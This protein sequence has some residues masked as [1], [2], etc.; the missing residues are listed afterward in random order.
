M[1]ILKV[2]HGYPKRYNAGSEVYS[3]MLCHGLSKSHEVQVFTREENIFEPD[4]HLREEKD[5]LN[6]KIHLNIINVPGERHKNRYNH[7]GINNAY[8]L[9]VLNFKPQIVHIGHLNHL[10]T[11]IIN[12]NLKYK[13]PTIYTLHDFWL[14][15]PRGQFLMRNSNPPFKLCSGQENQKCARQCYVGEGGGIDLDK[16]I[17]RAAD[18][19]KERMD[20]IRSIVMNVDHFISPSMVVAEKVA[21]TL[22][23]PDHK[24]TIM[25]YGFDHQR[26]LNRK[27]HPE[28][29]RAF[30]FG[31]IGTHIPSKGI[32]DLIKAFSLLD[33]NYKLR[34]WG[35]YHPLYT[36]YLK[37][38][39]KSLPETL[40]ERISFMGEYANEDIVPEIFNHVD[41]I[42]VPSIWYEN[43]PLVIHEA[44]QVKVP[45][46]ATRLGGMEEY[47]LHDV[48]GL[49]FEHRN[50]QSLS[51]EMSRLAKDSN[52]YSRIAN[53]GYLFS[54][55]SQIPKME[56][57]IR[58]IE[59]IYKKAIREKV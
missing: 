28:K 53:S 7:L 6:S 38:L 57:H 34:I 55:N 30:V 22:H 49:L 32:Q 39:V 14:A 10:S 2:I 9:I 24:I 20:H 40:Q 41:A 23:I 29:D 48:N 15:C 46:I 3:Q 19:V 18:W 44:Q 31:Y 5:E 13:I 54:A 52:L 51:D 8:S 11:G 37:E 36:P 26:L 50:V 42:V 45:V 56:D 58:E 35:R 47:I 12:E 16:D 27:R 43:S 25:D 4:Y 33:G 59:E 21:E 17:E 1:R